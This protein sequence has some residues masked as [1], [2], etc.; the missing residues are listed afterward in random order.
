MTDFQR[1]HYEQMIECVSDAT[2]KHKDRLYRIAESDEM[3]DLVIEHTQEFIGILINN[4]ADKFQEDNKKFNRNRFIK[5][6][7]CFY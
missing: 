2:S 7:K 4:L 3:Y 6:Y 5:T 1:R